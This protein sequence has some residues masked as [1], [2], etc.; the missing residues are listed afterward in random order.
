M[1]VEEAARCAVR[2]VGIGSP[3]GDDRAGWLV[4]ER[5]ATEAGWNPSTVVEV[6]SAGDPLRLVGLLEGCRRLIVV[7]AC[8]SG[9]PA[10]TVVRTTWG[11]VK[12]GLAGAPGGDAGPSSHGLGVAEALGLAEALGRVPDPDAVGLVGI[13]VG[14]EPG[15]DAGGFTPVSEPSAAVR[16]AIPAACR[17]VRELIENT[18]EPGDH[19]APGLPGGT[20]ATHAKPR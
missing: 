2:V 5:L 15:D 18:E 4:A 8:R 3:H 10:G 12:R 16:D 6:T 20:T 14:D 9:R 1:R 19:A 7:D 17:L 13:E 11:E